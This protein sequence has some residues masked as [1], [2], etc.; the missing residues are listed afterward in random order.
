MTVRNNTE[1]V[2]EE[3]DNPM[4]ILIGLPY[5]YNVPTVAPIF[6]EMSYWDTYFLNTGLILNGD[7]VQAK[8]STRAGKATPQR[9]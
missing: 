1:D 6:Q 3:G 4:G 8:N 2:G 9:K 5:P 7:L